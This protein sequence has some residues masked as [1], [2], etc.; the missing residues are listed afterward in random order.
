MAKVKALSK[1]EFFEVPVH[2]ILPDPDQP[3]QSFNE[4]ENIELANS[5]AKDGIL[6]P[7]LLR[8]I[9]STGP[10]QYMVVF[11]HRRLWAA[12]KANL[13]TIPARVKELTPE[14]ALH[15]QIIE[16]LQRKNINPMDE[17]D[18]F[19]RLITKSI[20]TA[21]QI[22]DELGV[23]TK[24]VY[25]RL[26]LKK[27]IEPVQDLIRQ[28][29]LTISH[30]KQFA[31]LKTEDQEKLWG[32]WASNIEEEDIA[33]GDL[34]REITN[35][36]CLKLENAIFSTS[37]AKLI[38]KAGSCEK[39]LKRSGCNLLLFDDIQQEDIC[40]DKECWQKKE[41]AHIAVEIKRL[42]K[43]GHKVVRL[44]ASYGE[45][46]E[47]VINNEDW[48]EVGEDETPD[49][50]GI[51]VVWSPYNRAYKIGQ[52]VPV[53][54]PHWHENEEPENEEE[55]DYDAG[56]NPLS[57]FAQRSQYVDHDEKINSLIYEALAKEYLNGSNFSPDLTSF[58]RTS[59]R[60]NL[61]NLD[62]E[63]FELLCEL[64][65][66]DKVNDADGDFD[67]EATLNLLMENT[68]D[69]ERLFQLA[70]L[71]SS[72]EY[73]E[74]NQQSVE[75]ESPILDRVGINL[76]QIIQAYAQSTDGSYTIPE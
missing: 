34:K 30:G 67:Q 20:T 36:F 26:A 16:N 5:V 69:L 22:G 44:S 13:G 31:R 45:A 60:R 54:I 37:D 70:E 19:S 38:P 7:I 14:E 32:N 40:F 68:A 51:I 1:V 23:S 41:E 56:G 53:F 18:A 71:A 66:W 4:E 65:G 10:S 57:R 11:G 50:V 28:G 35:S 6:Q 43:A 64:C 12:K 55:E 49:A 63:K 27:V 9:S 29:K 62:N 3:R 2:E 76:L 15:I 75:E 21:E 74:W 59:A 47:G 72:Y 17:A 8:P 58:F 61:N 52:L 39:C 33:I 25:D 24:Y 46:P 73:Q 42:E 48:N